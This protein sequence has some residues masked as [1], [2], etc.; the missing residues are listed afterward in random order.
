MFINHSTLV[1]IA[2]TLAI[3]TLHFREVVFVAKLDEYLF[4]AG[5]VLAQHYSKIIKNWMEC[6]KFIHFTVAKSS[7]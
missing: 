1:H 7:F 4:L 2:E 6:R 5:F 3:S